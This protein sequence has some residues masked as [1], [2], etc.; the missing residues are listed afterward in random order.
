MAD[1]GPSPQRTLEQRERVERIQRAVRSL[2][3]PQRVVFA[4]YA[5][6]EMTYGQIA[7]VLGIP[8]GTVMSRLYHARRQLAETLTDLAPPG[9]TQERS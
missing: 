5:T 9:G 8:V 3:E 2:P 7:E 6:G 1:A 4:L